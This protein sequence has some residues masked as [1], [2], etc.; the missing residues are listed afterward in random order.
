MLCFHDDALNTTKGLHFDKRDTVPIGL[1]LTPLN[2]QTIPKTYKLRRN[3]YDT[4]FP[5]VPT[6]QSVLRNNKYGG[7]F[8]SGTPYCRC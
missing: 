4:V 3:F 6:K 8:V 7:V 2:L 1:N 5:T